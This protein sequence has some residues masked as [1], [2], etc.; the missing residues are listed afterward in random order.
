MYAT[1]DELKLMHDSVLFPLMLDII[2]KNRQE[3]EQ[4]KHS[5]RGLYTA[6]LVRLRE[7]ILE[8]MQEYR[9][10]LIQAEIKMWKV[11][12]ESNSIKYKYKR[13]GYE[14]DFEL[15]RNVAR[16]ELST[17]FGKY[18]NQVGQSLRH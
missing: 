2:E 18:I 17:K 9:K 10:K 16:S 3:L 1:N 14:G 5:L 11:D 7:M 15:H 13:R 4:S 8:D 6:S 12:H